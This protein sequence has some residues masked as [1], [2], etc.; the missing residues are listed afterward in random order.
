M[1]QGNMTTADQASTTG[2]R[3]QSRQAHSAVTTYQREQV[4][5]LSPVE[6]IHKLYDVAIVSCK[7]GD[8]NRAQRALNELIISLNFEHKVIAFGLYRLYD[9]CKRCIG[10]G[11]S[12]EAVSILEELRATW[13]KAFQI[14]N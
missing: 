4:M 2:R 6:V 13:A 11:K 5:N 8:L 9:Y 12:G 7:K 10:D 1:G 14:Q 3:Y